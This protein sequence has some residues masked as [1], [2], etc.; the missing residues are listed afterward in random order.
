MAETPKSPTLLT[1]V[2]SQNIRQEKEQ[3]YRVDLVS[4]QIL[5]EAIT[6]PLQLDQKLMNRSIGNILNALRVIPFLKKRSNKTQKKNLDHSSNSVDLWKELLEDENNKKVITDGFWLI[7]LYKN[8]FK[9]QSSSE[10]KLLYK[11]IESALLDRIACNY[12]D[13][14]QKYEN[15][16]EAR[17]F[18]QIYFDILAQGVFYC[19]FYS[20][21]KSRPL[22]DNE[23]KIYIFKIF[24]YLLTGLKISHKSTFI[25]GWSFIE[26]WKL[27]LGDGDVL[28]QSKIII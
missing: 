12:I 2:T 22:F 1:D 5:K 8:E 23:Y 20:F 16:N 18:F 21:P 27:D 26:S 9:F 25:T 14:T 4:N 19:F 10:D 24:S 3:I 6:A 17:R 28:K 11:K 15:K 13:F 7:I